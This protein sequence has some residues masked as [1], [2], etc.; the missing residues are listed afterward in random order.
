MS[1]GMFSREELNK[2]YGFDQTADVD[3]QSTIAELFDVGHSLVADIGEAE[4]FASLL[5]LHLP[6]KIVP[7]PPLC[8]LVQHLPLVM[9][10]IRRL[11][12]PLLECQ[13]AR[14]R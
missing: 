7:R 10:S 13:R 1:P 3:T 4:L 12:D 5:Q 6:M 9:R 8:L 14:R 11:P 2:F